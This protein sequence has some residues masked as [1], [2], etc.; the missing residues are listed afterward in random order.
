MVS[1]SLA[2][3]WLAVFAWS[4]IGQSSQTKLE[5]VF[6]N[7]SHGD[8][9]FLRTSKG[10]TALIDAGYP[11]AGTFDYLEENGITHLDIL[12][13]THAHEDHIGGMP[14]VFQAA[15]VDEFIENG[16]MLDS[17]YDEALEKSLRESGVRRKIVRTGDRIPFGDLTFEV[18]NPSKARPDV[19]NN[20]SI[21]LLLEVGEIRF[22]FTGDIEKPIEERLVK[23]GRDLHV[24]ILKVAHHAGNTSSD[25][26][27]LEAVKPDAAIY[28]AS[29]S[30]PGF[31]NEDTLDNL[32]IAG[33]RV[34]GTNFNG[35]IKVETDGR[36]YSITTETGEPLQP[37]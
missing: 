25:P 3:I 31:P 2:A 29:N 5:V 13:A 1:V 9:I 20:N 18:L 34:Y 33:A 22:L 28:S 23:S 14:Q 35:T 6:I 36:S 4:T 37:Y 27:F 16:Q 12:V 11:D 21:V 24:A 17:P 8:S 15:Q 19:V 30:F 7:V 32:R 26:V 10:D